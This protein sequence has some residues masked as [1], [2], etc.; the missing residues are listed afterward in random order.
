MLSRMPDRTHDVASSAELRSA[1]GSAPSIG[2]AILLVGGADVASA[3]DL[4]GIRAFVAALVTMAERSG[5]AIVDGGTDSGVM[6]LIGEEREARGAT[7][8]LVGVVPRGA[9]ERTTRS[10]QRINTAPGHSHILLVPGSEFGDEIEWLF[11]A[12]DHLAGASAPTLVVNGGD[13]TMVE[14]RMRIDLGHPVVA[15]EGS[16]RAADELAADASLRGSGRLRLIGLDA[17]EDELAAI[18]NPLA[19]R[20]ADEGIKLEGG[21]R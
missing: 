2:G 5:M 16:G 13:M 17:D 7:F 18:I 10:G 9:L 20:R 11:A 1:L 4:E 12:A 14:A 6:R 3:A 8:P 19:G 21:G 15:V